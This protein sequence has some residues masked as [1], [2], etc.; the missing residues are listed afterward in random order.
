MAGRLFLLLAS[1]LVGLIGLELGL[2]LTQGRDG[3]TDWP[4]LV[5]RARAARRLVH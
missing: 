4:N 1:I 5:A 2:R 3:L